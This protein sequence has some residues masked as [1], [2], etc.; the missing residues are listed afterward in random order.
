MAQ[1]G[2]LRRRDAYSSIPWRAGPFP[3]LQLKVFDET[4]DAD[5]VFIGSSQL[6]C[7]VDTPYVQKQLSQQLGREAEVFTLGWPWSGFDAAYTIAHN[8]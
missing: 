3:W 5:I 8:C 1:T 4:K 7:D 6:W 2:V